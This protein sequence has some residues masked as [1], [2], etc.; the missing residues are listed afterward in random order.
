MAKDINNQNEIVPEEQDTLSPNTNKSTEPYN[1][2]TKVDLNETA[3]RNIDI[4]DSTDDR[5]PQKGGLLQSI[6]D[7]V[8]SAI[9]WI[10]SPEYRYV[11]KTM[12]DMALRDMLDEAREAR[13]EQIKKNTD[14]HDN[15]H[16]GKEEP[17]KDNKTQDEPNKNPEVQENP[18]KGTEVQEAPTNIVETALKRFS[19]PEGWEGILVDNKMIV[20]IPAVEKG[21]VNEMPDYYVQLEGS[22]INPET[23]QVNFENAF[24]I[25]NLEN[26]KS[27]FFPLDLTEYKNNG[28]TTTAVPAL[29][30]TEEHKALRFYFN[31]EALESSNKERVEITNE[32]F[33]AREALN[34]SINESRHEDT[35]HNF[36]KLQETLDKA[37]TSNC[38]EL[39]RMFEAFTGQELT[40]KPSQEL[41]EM[42]EN[43]QIRDNGRGCLDAL[44]HIANEALHPDINGDP[45]IEA[46]KAGHL[47]DVVNLSGEIFYAGEEHE[48]L[49]LSGSDSDR[50][51]DIV[52]EVTNK[53]VNI[54]TERSYSTASELVNQEYLHMGN[55]TLTFDGEDNTFKLMFNGN[56]EPILINPESL[57]HPGSA[58]GVAAM[59]GTVDRILITEEDQRN[60]YTF[61]SPEEAEKYFDNMLDR[62]E[63]SGDS[64]LENSAAMLRQMING[65]SE[66]APP[67]QGYDDRE[68]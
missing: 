48:S 35:I 40:N 39:D 41:K 68:L 52:N 64:T 55:P 13:A 66:I 60:L 30:S 49:R 8:V 16:T 17:N 32:I 6:W 25:H 18:N 46:Q 63:R 15:E 7:F 4:Y 56:E 54:I 65:D 51:T 23:L 14:R 33:T 43:S 1:D 11:T 58:F 19:E 42:Y 44:E 24:L 9:K 47:I 29:T 3:K 28:L 10:I 62:Y 22:N 67:T 37:K 27:E 57:D 21:N 59:S 36:V 61:D 20:R 26:G 45:D 12:H 31:E 5:N 50:F 34:K 2:T 53:M 38:F